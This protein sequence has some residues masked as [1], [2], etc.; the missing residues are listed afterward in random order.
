M[1]WEG[2]DMTLNKSLFNLGIFKNTIYR[3]KWGSLLYFVALFFSVPF[4]LLV[5]DFDRLAERMLGSSIYVPASIILRND[6]LMIPMLLATVV[7][8]VVAVLVF[9]NVHSGKQG[10]FTHGLPC[11]R[12]KSYISNLAAA[13]ALMGTPVLAN[14]VILLVMSF[15]R[16]GQ[17]FSSM[18]V[19]YWVGLNFNML[20]VMFSVA[21]FSA[22]LTGNTMAH[23]G[24]NVFL[25]LVPLIVGWAIALIS[26]KFLY[27]C[28]Q[29][30]NFIATELMS[31]DPVVWIFGMSLSHKGI[32]TE[33]QT[34]VYV[35]GAALMYVLGF[36]LYRNRK[37]E[38]CGDIAAF[39][40][41]KPILKYAVVSGVAITL[42]GLLNSMEMGAVA[43]VVVVL[44]LCA[45]AYFAA[46]MLIN[47]SFKVFKSSYKGFCG[48]VVCCAVLIGFFAY[49]SVFGYETRVPK[50]EEIEKAGLYTQWGWKESLV[51]DDPQ[52]IENTI[53]IHEEIISDIPVTAGNEWDY[54]LFVSYK[55]KNG[56]QMQRRYRISPELYDKVMRAM[57]KSKEYKLGITEINNVNIENV[58]SLTLS[59]RSFGFAYDIALNDDAPELMQMIKK[60]VEELSYEELEKSDN[61]LRISAEFDCTAE[62][63]ERLKYF[64]NSEYDPFD[65]EA[66][67]VYL[68]FR[69]TLNANFKNTYNFL[70]EKGYYD[71]IIKQLG[72]G[73][74]I[75]KE[76]IFSAGEICTY[77][78]VTGEFSE[79]IISRNDCVDLE[80][81]DE[82]VL[83]EVMATQR[84]TEISDGKSYMV[85][86]GLSN[87]G[88]EL[89]A[90]DNAMIINA[91][92]MPEYLKK[93]VKE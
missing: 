83:A 85:Y 18:S 82:Q 59:A 12:T 58:K 50:P 48:F 46:E 75:C 10:I 2:L 14:G 45:I 66:K 65:N 69:L 22:F 4:L 76:P 79:F 80:G 43:I 1:S 20:F 77:K 57:Y 6:Y 7:P 29:S 9:N 86:V 26:D 28:H 72:Q 16:F 60:D 32:F 90:V 81:I 42:F 17:L 38:A 24:I 36:L 23:I 30:D 31:N 40:V 73:I 84:S 47:K 64:K 25:H 11:D 21:V 93:Y 62:E 87:Y 54:H 71:T 19:L 34:W 78:G 53:A 39:N 3:F 35:I 41:F 88:E 67:Y 49:T 37:I 33:A 44:I 89:Y 68:N 52:L 55:L 51:F 5:A 27:G 70:K 91:E 63:N 74:V 15:G 13:F 92:K 8:T 56:T 61:I